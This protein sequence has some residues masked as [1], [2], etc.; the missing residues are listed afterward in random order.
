MFV[1]PEPTITD[2]QRQHISLVCTSST[3]A[4]LGAQVL[5]PLKFVNY[6]E[7]SAEFI[8]SHQLGYHLYADDTQ[9][10]GRTKISEVPYTVNQLQ[11]CIVDL[12]DW[13]ASR[14]LQLNLSKTE[15]S[16]TNCRLN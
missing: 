1:I 7:D 12:R 9:V 6:T 14:R 4:Y 5:G 16:G 11:Q 8:T 3:A 10:A 2:L 15:L 13:C